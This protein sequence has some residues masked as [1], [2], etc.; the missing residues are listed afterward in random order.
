MIDDT[1]PPATATA[2]ATATAK[3]TPMSVTN[4]SPFSRPLVAP[5]HTSV[6]AQPQR[7]TLI[8][9]TAT[10]CESASDPELNAVVGA[11]DLASALG[12]TFVVLDASPGGGGRGALER[13]ATVISAAPADACETFRAALCAAAAMT[14]GDGVV[15]WLGRRSATSCASCRGWRR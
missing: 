1:A 6:P 8:L 11:A 9:C 15:A 14:A 12:L 13:A 5:V 7:P 10:Q 4:I 3:V 2:T